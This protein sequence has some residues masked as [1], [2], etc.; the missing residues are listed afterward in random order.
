M[1]TALQKRLGG[2]FSGIR[3][4]GGCPTIWHKPATLVSAVFLGLISVA[5]LARVIL[6]VRLTA[7][8]VAIPLWASIVA[9]VFAGAL[10][11]LLWHENRG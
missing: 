11:F 9:C 4:L 5:Q 1:A 6:D 3:P 7:N 8:G 10:A 2:F